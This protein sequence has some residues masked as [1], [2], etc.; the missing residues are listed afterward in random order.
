MELLLVN[1]QIQNFKP[2]QTGDLEPENRECDICFEPF[3]LEEEPITLLS[4]GHIFGHDCLYHW[5][6]QLLPSV[7]D[8][9]GKPPDNL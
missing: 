5:V 4:C 7:D 3:D 9:T 8:L 1:Q 2:V 6:A